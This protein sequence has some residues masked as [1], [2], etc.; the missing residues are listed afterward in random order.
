MKI[1]IPR[2]VGIALVFV[3]LAGLFFDDVPP[4]LT[5]ARA[6]AQDRGY[7]W[8]AFHWWKKSRTVSARV[9]LS[10]HK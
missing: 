8:A 4:L 6:G 2:C 9:V 7:S 10:R 3:L 1:D 5:R